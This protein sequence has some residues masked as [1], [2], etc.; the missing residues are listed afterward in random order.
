MGGAEDTNVGNMIYQ[1]L[2][3]QQRTAVEGLAM[4]LNKTQAAAKA[5]IGVNTL[6]KWLTQSHV[7]RYM[8]QLQQDTSDMISVTKPKVVQMLMEAIEDAKLQ[9]DPGVQIKGLRE[10]GLM[11]GFYAPEERHISYTNT[12]AQIQR[13]LTEMSEKDLLALAG[14]DSNVIEGDF[15]RV[16]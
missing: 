9:S 7:Q 4:G 15:R 10:L 5:N 13:H 16:E 2:S 11:L 8:A 14:K 12:E 3:P 1:E 6:S